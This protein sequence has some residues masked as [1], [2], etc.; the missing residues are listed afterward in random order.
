MGYCEGVC[1]N[2]IFTNSEGE[3]KNEPGGEL[4]YKINMLGK[5]CGIC[6]SFGGDW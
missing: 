1:E 6:K 4:N 5:N 3:K 2:S